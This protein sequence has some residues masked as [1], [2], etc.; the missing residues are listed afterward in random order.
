MVDVL[1]ARDNWMLKL[2]M[3][4]LL[5]TELFPDD[6]NFSKFMQVHENEENQSVSLSKEAKRVLLL[7][8][9][10]YKNRNKQ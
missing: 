8:N 6:P 2:A 7:V 3:K 1:N 5:N 9:T 10:R 4:K